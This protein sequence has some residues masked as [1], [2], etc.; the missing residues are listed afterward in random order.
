MTQTLRLA[1][2]A[3]EATSGE[4][5]LY[6]WKELSKDQFRFIKPFL[7]PTN[8]KADSLHCPVNCMHNCSREVCLHDEDY[9]KVIVSCGCV[10]DHNKCG[11]S[12]FPVLDVIYHEIHWNNLSQELARLLG[13]D[14]S[15]QRIDS[16][17]YLHKIGEYTLMECRKHPVYF[18]IPCPAEDIR[19]IISYLYQMQGDIK[20]ILIVPTF[21]DIKIEVIN[22]I[23]KNGC[24]IISLHDITHA[25]TNG[26]IEISCSLNSLFIDFKK[27]IL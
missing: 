12:I 11:I 2:K 7:V 8:N 24:E 19:R 13:I 25:Q 17:Q 20:F 6:N 3:L 21:Q 1:W 10:N 18:A 4:A 9:S 15:Y 23:R 14:A 22:T 16:C 27:N 26:T 5:P